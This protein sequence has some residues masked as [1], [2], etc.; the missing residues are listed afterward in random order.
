VENYALCLWNMKTLLYSKNSRQCRE[1]LWLPLSIV[2]VAELERSI[3]LERQKAGIAA[4]KA[5][6]SYKSGRPVVMTD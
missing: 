5:R 1:F 2:A 3:I 6:G 4:A